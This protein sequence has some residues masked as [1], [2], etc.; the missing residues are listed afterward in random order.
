MRNPFKATRSQILF[1]FF[2]YFFSSFQLLAAMHFTF[3]T[4][5]NKHLPISQSLTRR[6][7]RRYKGKAGKQIDESYVEIKSINKTSL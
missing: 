1:F 5:A 4:L 6:R 7:I 3:F 2:C